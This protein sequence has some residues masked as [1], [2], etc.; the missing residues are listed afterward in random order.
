MNE[1]SQDK[2]SAL[3]VVRNEKGQIIKGTANPNGRPKGSISV[4]TRLKQ[5]FE[6]N[7]EDFEEFVKAYKADPSNRKHI[8]EMIDGKPKQDIDVKGDLNINVV[9]YGN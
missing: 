5:M 9:N 3:Q 8:T 7:P 6:E 4:I 2:T 1:E